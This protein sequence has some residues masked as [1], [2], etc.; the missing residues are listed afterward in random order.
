MTIPSFLAPTLLAQ[1]LPAATASVPP[2]SGVPAPATAATPLPALQNFQY[3][4]AHQS[5][6]A[7]HY[8]WLT[9]TFATLFMLSALGLI[10]LLAVQTTKQ[11]GLSGTLGGR[12]ESVYRTRLGF[13]RQLARVTSIVAIAFVI[14]AFIISLSGI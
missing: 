7:L 13:D 11:E 6:L 10:V 1:F 3:S 9:H 4:A 12:V 14:I 8:P 5:P 2:R